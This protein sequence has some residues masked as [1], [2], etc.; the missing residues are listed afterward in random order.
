MPRARNLKPGFFMNDLLAE[1]TPLGRLLFAGL[2]T[3]ADR[4]G[5]L[6]DRPKKIKA[7]V[8]PFDNCNVE[9]L[10]DELA[11]RDFI[12]R[13][14]ADGHRIIQV[15]NFGKHQ[16]PHIKEPPSS[17]PEQ[18]KHQASTVQAPDTAP[19]K[20]GASTSRAGL[21]PDSGFLIPDSKVPTTSGADAPDAC[22]QL[23]DTGV[24]LLVRSGEEAKAA[25]TLIGRLRSQLGDNDA[26]QVVL[27]ASKA[28][29]PKPFITAAMH[30]PRKGGRTVENF[31]PSDY[32]LEAVNGAR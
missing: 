6:L 24:D 28:T 10:L 9:R 32:N 30:R 7:E 22:K 17:L 26:L 11:K 20:H 18:P 1:V 3:I 16:N 4:E 27:Q 25:R 12:R 5:R 31:D 13:Y 19:D 23:F 8:L 21:I 15:T 29:E 14:E 2:W